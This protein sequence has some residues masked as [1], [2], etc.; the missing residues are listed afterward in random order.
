MRGLLLLPAI[1]GGCT[2]NHLVLDRARLE[3][4]VPMP[5][6]A[7]VPDSARPGSVHGQLAVW[8]M[9]TDD[10]IG[11][12]MRW[13][14]SPVG[15]QAQIQVVAGPRLRWIAGGGFSRT[16]SM[17]TGP[18]LSVRNSRLRWD[19]EMLVGATRFRSR[20]EG[21][22]VP[23]GVD[24]EG[25]SATDESAAADQT[26]FWGQG[27]LRCRAVRSGPWTELRFLPSFSWGDLSKASGSVEELRVRK[28]MAALGAGWLQETRGGSLWIL[29]GRVIGIGDAAFPQLVL[30]WQT[31][32]G[33]AKE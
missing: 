32:I 11:A 7:M 30:S 23:H 33:G 4:D 19:A 12:G 3:A 25:L 29:G 15:A 14:R 6:P 9:E 26:G 1:L 20:L 10:S 24:E 22:W 18:V 16:L 13:S 2:V 28:T 5:P 31:P 27:T 8:T 21:R 17:W